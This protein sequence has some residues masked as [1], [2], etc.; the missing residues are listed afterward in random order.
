MSEFITNAELRIE[1]ERLCDENERLKAKNAKLRKLVQ[2]ALNCKTNEGCCEDCW[3]EYGECPIE[4]EM[5][6]LGIEAK[7]A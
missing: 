4:M 2:R 3:S 7:D 1:A 5:R 6:E